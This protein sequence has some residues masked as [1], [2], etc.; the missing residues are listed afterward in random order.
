M[1][2]HQLIFKTSVL[3]FL[4]LNCAIFY[5]QETDN[6]DLD[7][8][9]GKTSLGFGI[10]DGLGP[11]VRQYLNAQ[12]VLEAGLYAGSTLAPLENTGDSKLASDLH[13]EFGFM[14]DFAVHAYGKRF[15]KEEKRR[16]K[17]HGF[18]MRTGH[19]FG[20]FASSILAA[21]WTQEVFPERNPRRSFI[22]EAGLKGYLPHW[23]ARQNSINS[24]FDY[25]EPKVR[26]FPYLRLHWNFF[27]K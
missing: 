6:I 15:Y 21:G 16:I 24:D 13:T 17:V 18:T 25:K 12:T 23:D 1:K 10:G 19:V 2:K 5:G 14:I 26:P 9:G 8:F 11:I 20:K 27:V 3:L 7:R 22:L 4:S